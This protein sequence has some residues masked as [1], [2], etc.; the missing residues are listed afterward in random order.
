MLGSLR[1][2]QSVRPE[3]KFKNLDL[4]TQLKCLEAI[5]ENLNE[6]RGE[7]EFLREL[8]DKM[9]DMHS[10]QNELEH[11]SKKALNTRIAS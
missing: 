6:I 9:I 1:G 7:L 10:I 2:P 3:M 11:L 8:S 5:K 4:Q